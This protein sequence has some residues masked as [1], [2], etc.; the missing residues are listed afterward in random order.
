ML[1]GCVVALGGGRQFSAVSGGDQRVALRA[2]RRRGEAP[3]RDIFGSVSWR[4]EAV[5]RVEEPCL[6]L[7][8]VGVKPTRMPQIDIND[9]A[10]AVPASASQN[11]PSDKSTAAEAEPAAQPTPRSARLGLRSAAEAVIGA[12]R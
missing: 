10:A 12:L 5:A 3:A 4:R 7:A 9:A 11:E 6:G 8:A 1:A 2:G